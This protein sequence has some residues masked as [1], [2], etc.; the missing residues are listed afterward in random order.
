MIIFL[1]LPLFLFASA[2]ILEAANDDFVM[3]TSVALLDGVSKDVWAN[4]QNVPTSKKSA[5][6][7]NIKIKL[8]NSSA[9]IFDSTFLTYSDYSAGRREFSLM[10]PL[11]GSKKCKSFQTEKVDSFNNILYRVNRKACVSIKRVDVKNYN[12]KYSTVEDATTPILHSTDGSSYFGGTKTITKTASSFDLKLQPNS[13]CAFDRITASYISTH[14]L[15]NNSPSVITT[16][17]GKRA[18]KTSV[19]RWK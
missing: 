16:F 9:E 1:G 7:A 14:Y 10:M 2:E 11:D 12:V 13:R 3:V 15:R 8:R 19:C 6:G 17:T 18:G 5:H 4:G